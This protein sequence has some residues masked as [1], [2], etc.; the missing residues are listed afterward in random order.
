MSE[1]LEL[2]NGANID[3]SYDVTCNASDHTL[4]FGAIGDFTTVTAADCSI[5]NS[6][7]ATSSPPVGDVWFLVAGR[8]AQRYS[9]VGQATAG[10]R[11]LSSVGA[12]CPTLVA[13][14]LTATCP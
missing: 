2:T 5:G 9:S 1:S 14:D 11:T 4:L 8:E 10:E 12:Q 6:G 13:Q 7:T 3:V